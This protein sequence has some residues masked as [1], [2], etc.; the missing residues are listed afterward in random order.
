MVRY[1]S[2]ERI[3]RREAQP[4]QGRQ[5]W[6]VSGIDRNPIL[7]LG[8]ER[9]DGRTRVLRTDRHLEPGESLTA[10]GGGIALRRGVLG[11][12]DCT[13]VHDVEEMAVVLDRT[14]EAPILRVA[15]SGRSAG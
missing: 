9:I 1:S 7:H 10:A 2:G 6:C 11:F 14:V 12:I 4:R 5:L 3:V 8:V 15:A 13:Q